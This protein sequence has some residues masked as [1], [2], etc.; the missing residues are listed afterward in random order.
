MKK[1]ADSSLRQ[2]QIQKKTQN[3]LKKAFASSVNPGQSDILKKYLSQSV[4]T[5]ENAVI[6]KEFDND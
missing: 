4:V 5:E 3:K 2:K 1:L 6:S